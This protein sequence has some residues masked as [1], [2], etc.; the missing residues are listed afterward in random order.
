MCHST[1]ACEKFY[2][3]TDNQTAISTKRAIEK[4]TMARHF[5]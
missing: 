2:Q 1:Q 3:Q 4:L 5:T